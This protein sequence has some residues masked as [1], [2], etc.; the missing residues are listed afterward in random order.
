MILIILVCSLV[1]ARKSKDDPSE[2]PA[3]VFADFGPHLQRDSQ[4]FAH[5]SFAEVYQVR[6]TVKNEKF[7]LKWLRSGYT[8]DEINDEVEF[9]G[10]VMKNAPAEYFLPCLGYFRR[11]DST[12]HSC[13]A[14][15]PKK[16]LAIGYL[17]P[18]CGQNMQKIIDRGNNPAPFSQR[19][20]DMLHIA[21]GLHFLHSQIKYVH[22]D[23]KPD[24]IIICS[25]NP[26]SRFRIID[27]MPDNDFTK[28]DIHAL[29]Q[30]NQ[31]YNLDHMHGTREYTGPELFN[32]GN[33]MGSFDVFSWS[34]IAMQ[35]LYGKDTEMYRLSDSYGSIMSANLDL[36]E[37]TTERAI[38]MSFEL[39]AS[40]FERLHV[41]NEDGLDIISPLEHFD[42]D[43][44]HFSAYTLVLSAIRATSLCNPL[45][46]ATML[47]IVTKWESGTAVIKPVS[48]LQ[49]IHYAGKEFEKLD[50]TR[51][52]IVL[53]TENQGISMNVVFNSCTSLNLDTW[54]CGF[55]IKKDCVVFNS[56]QQGRAEPEKSLQ[57]SIQ[58]STPTRADMKIIEN[59]FCTFNTRLLKATL[60]KWGHCLR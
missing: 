15:D 59:R 60:D 34:M 54:T 16:H 11:N 17:M 9:F 41:Q 27:P 10:K 33:Y 53:S 55:I 45:E 28:G 22:G 6:D 52:G 46:R 24:N 40:K 20:K 8:G 2:T 12:M 47:A 1:W 4:S 19:W 5:G 57:N 14:F 58:A 36:P 44:V 48:L 31:K 3:I 49:S 42:S 21:K 7:A 23:F 43:Q 51:D 29:L 32:V 26:D 37:I 35:Y 56:V 39:C 38:H 13:T 50:V 30:N 25:D 18:F